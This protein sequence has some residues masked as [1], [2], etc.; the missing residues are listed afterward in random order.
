[1]VKNTKR[2]IY[3]KLDNI[4]KIVDLRDKIKQQEGELK[5]LFQHYD[6]LNLQENQI[7][8]NWNNYLEDI[9]QK[10]DHVRL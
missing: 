6:D 4:E 2:E 10:L 3:I 8:E 1:M 7:F 5:K 9:N